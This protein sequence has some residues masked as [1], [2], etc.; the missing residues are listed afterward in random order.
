MEA[1]HPQSASQLITQ[2][3]LICCALLVALPSLAQTA[4]AAPEEDIR[5]PRGLI[6]LPSTP[7]ADYRAWWITAAVLAL[8]AIAYFAWKWWK[9]A[10]TP[11]TAEAIALQALKNVL[12]DRPDE[13]FANE[14]SAILRAYIQSRYSIPATQRS[15]EEFLAEITADSTLGRHQSKLCDFLRS[16]DRA[17][18]ANCPLSSE[19]RKDLVDQ[20]TTFV[21]ETSQ[22][23]PATA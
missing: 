19:T 1:F 16:C 22:P 21:V 18:F 13:T 10:H 3:R 9:N 12:F 4:P 15:T 5:G 7:V 14:V 20:A 8:L 23:T 11:P 2:L 6:G 17:K